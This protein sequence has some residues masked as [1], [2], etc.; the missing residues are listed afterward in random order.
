MPAIGNITIN[1]AT[2]TATVFTPRKADPEKSIWVKSGYNAS[3]TFSAADSLLSLG[4]SPA[5]G[6]RPTTRVKGEISFP[7]PSYV[8][9]DG[10]DL[11]TA[12]LYVTAIVPDDFSEAD[13]GHFEALCENFISDGVFTSAIVDSEGSY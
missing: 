5:S 6:K 3:N 12:R 2:P 7:N 9:A 10:L 4:V 13:R 1:D 8:V 11:S